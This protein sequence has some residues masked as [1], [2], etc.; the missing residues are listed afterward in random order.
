MPF[1]LLPSSSP[2]HLIGLIRREWV[3]LSAVAFGAVLRV[4]QLS[5]QVLFGDEWHAIHT[6]I[7]SGYSEVLSSFGAADHSIPITLYYKICMDTVGLSEWAI[8]FP[9]LVSGALTVFILPLLVRTQVS[10]FTADLFAWL[11]ALSPELIFYSRFARPYAITVLF[12][13]AAAILF[14]SWWGTGNRLH[15]LLYIVL[16]ILTGYLLLVALPFVF[17]PFVFSFIL[18]ITGRSQE[19]RRSIRR[20][21]GLATVTVLP[22]IILLW[23][24]LH[25][26]FESLANKA[27]HSHIPFLA[28]AG[29]F[30]LL[31]GMEWSLAV[32][33]IGVLAVAGLV[34]MW[35]SARP[36]AGYLMTLSVIQV[37]AILLVRP[38]GGVSSHILARYLLLV[39]PILLLFTAAGLETLPATIGARCNKWLR[40]VLSVALCVVFFAGGPILAVSYR[41]NNATGLLLLIHALFGKECQDLLNRVPG[42]YR[43]LASHPAASLTIVEAPFHWPGDHIPLY[44]QIHRQTVL[45]GL[46]DNLCGKGKDVHAQK[47]GH[48]VQLETIVDLNDIDMLRS[49]RVN[50]VIFHKWLQGEVRVPLPGYRDRDMS[51]CISKYRLRFGAPI[52]EDRDIVVFSVGKG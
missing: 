46:T 18:I 50:F 11:L 45:M 33:L 51:G 41:P 13:F 19:R 44:Q 36:F 5:G 2:V 38:I 7:S 39:L 35:R 8:R 31:T 47:S 29:A 40:P 28:W 26:D 52:F 4:H 23:T 49:R 20:L 43:T 37:M 34:R 9:F 10:R 14:Y 22:L 3:F 25:A 30:R 21:V 16:T 1:G 6:A 17:G 24:P 32:I 15:G 42:F 27:G 12:G 48:G